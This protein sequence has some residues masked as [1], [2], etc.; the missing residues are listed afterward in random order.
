VAPTKPSKLAWEDLAWAAGFFDGEGCFSCAAG[1]AAIFI[2]QVDREPLD[3][4]R[5]TIGAGNVNGPYV[6]RSPIRPSKQD[7][8]AFNAYGWNTLRRVT[9]L[10]WPNLGAGKRMQAAN[11]FERAVSPKGE[12]PNR[13]INE[14]SLTYE[15]GWR[16]KLAWAAGFFDGEGCFSW[17]K[18]SRSMCVSIAQAHTGV[19]ERFRDA[20][21]IGRLYGPYRRGPSDL[22]R[23]PLYFYRAQGQ[24]QV[25]AV[26]AMLWFKLGGAK[27]QQAAAVVARWPRTC[28]RGHPLVRRQGACPTCVALYWKSRREGR[29][30][31]RS[32]ATEARWGPVK[33]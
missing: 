13:T 24:E 27:R 15:P 29:S 12:K 18:S 30:F 33:R 11:V 9:E 14:L 6:R 23:S 10:L 26:A 2:G 7:Q 20:V 19:L 5:A 3:R 25:Q 8:Y 4:F 1:Y 28:H 31:Q 22:G 32:V 21:G 17:S 16:E